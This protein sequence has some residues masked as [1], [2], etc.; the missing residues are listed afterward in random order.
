MQ[1]RPEIAEIF[2]VAVAV[3]DGEVGVGFGQVDGGEEQTVGGLDF[4]DLGIVPVGTAAGEDDFVSK[5]G[6]GNQSCQQED[7]DGIK[8]LS[9]GEFAAED[10]F[11][12]LIPHDR[13][14]VSQQEGKGNRDTGKR[15]GSE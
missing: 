8:Q 4:E 14:I 13:R 11:G 1:N 2:A 3:E 9:A 7:K 10:L 15:A 5:E 6:H 12:C